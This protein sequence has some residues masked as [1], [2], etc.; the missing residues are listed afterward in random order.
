MYVYCAFVVILVSHVESVCVCV[1]C[2]G[3]VMLQYQI[4]RYKWAEDI[5]E[6]KEKIP[7]VMPSFIY[8]IVT[9]FILTLLIH[10]CANKVNDTRHFLAKPFWKTKC[11]YLEPLLFCVLFLYTKYHEA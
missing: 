5:A 7:L 1:V 11:D 2:L 10:C 4:F 8:F 3:L 9:L 6:N